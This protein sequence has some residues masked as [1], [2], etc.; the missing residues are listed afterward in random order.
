[1]QEARRSLCQSRTTTAPHTASH[2]SK[3][4]IHL[5]RTVTLYG[6]R[7]AAIH[8][9]AIQLIHHTSPYTLPQTKTIYVCKRG[10]ARWCSLRKE[11][12]YA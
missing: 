9:T 4:A 8:H 12:A 6:Y 1:M 2:T 11:T 7:T 5:T 3:T 10:Y